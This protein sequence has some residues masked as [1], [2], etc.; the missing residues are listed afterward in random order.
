MND[1]FSHIEILQYIKG[2]LDSIAH[3][4][5]FCNDNK[6]YTV[7]LLDKVDNDIEATL[8]EFHKVKNWS[9]KTENITENWRVVLQREL[10]PYFNQIIKDVLPAVINRQNFDN[11]IISLIDKFCDCLEKIVSI[12]GQLLKVEIDWNSGEYEGFYECYENDY[13]FDLGDK[14]LFLHFGSSD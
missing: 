13:L 7:D 8:R 6:T 12:N 5:S 2:Y 1:N 11:N 14:I 4:N 3:L 10:T 9:V